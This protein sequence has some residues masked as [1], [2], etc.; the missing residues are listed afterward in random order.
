MI[1]KYYKYKSKYQNY[2]ILFEIGIFY[3]VIGCDS[4][5]INQLFDYKLSKI[6]NTFKC[7]FPLK[8]IISIS[9]EL[10]ASS[11]NYIIVKDDEIIEKQEFENN[12]YDNYSFNERIVYYNFLRIEKISSILIDNVT[13]QDI[14]DKLC[15]IENIIDIK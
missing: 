15:E 8:N 6:S 13:N 2:I 4:L 14:D 7:G 1:E 12:N 9:R 10:S 11:I 5:I 3:E